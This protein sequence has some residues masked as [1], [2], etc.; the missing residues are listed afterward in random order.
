M[1]VVE[2]AA[3]I[4][5][6]LDGGVFRKKVEAALEES[7]WPR[8]RVGRV[9]TSLSRAVQRLDSEG[10]IKLVNK[11]DAM[12]VVTLTGPASRDWRV[13]SHIGLTVVGAQ[14]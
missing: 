7:S 11:S 14:R 5:P 8:L 12:G 9:S 2:R 6:V 1:A 4:L 10:T 13:V 3:L